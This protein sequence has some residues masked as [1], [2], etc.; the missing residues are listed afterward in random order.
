LLPA[1]ALVLGY[2][3]AQSA[4]AESLRHLSLEEALQRLEAR[5]LSILYSSDLVQPSMRV[6]EEPRATE[7]REILEEILAPHGLQVKDGPNG[8]L[9]LVRAPKAPAESQ[10]AGIPPPPAAAPWRELEEVIVSASHYQF[11]RETSPSVTTMS[12]AD[13]EVLPDLGDDPVRA[14]AR[15]PGVASSEFSAKSNMRGG[16]ADETLFR[17][18]VS[19]GCAC[20]TRFTSRIFKASS[21]RSTRA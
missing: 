16:E 6:R 1:C 19:T 11:V 10:V 15:L 17:F 21:A 14:L 7:P 4:L 9:M 20:R 8:S 12:A 3:A 18:A 5:G 13:L 2:L